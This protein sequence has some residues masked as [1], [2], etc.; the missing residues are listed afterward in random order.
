MVTGGRVVCRGFW[1]AHLRPCVMLQAGGPAELTCAS[2]C[3]GPLEPGSESFVNSYPP[4]VAV[5]DTGGGVWLLRK[6][7]GSDTFFLTRT[8]PP[9]GADTPS[10]AVTSLCWRASALIGGS[11]NGSI[12]AWDVALGRCHAVIRFWIDVHRLVC[13]CA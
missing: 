8:Q 10:T 5:G 1:V 12:A 13:V 2:F 3:Q 11:A 6:A 7:V 4:S 9:W